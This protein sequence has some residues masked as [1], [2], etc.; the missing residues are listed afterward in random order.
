MAKPITKETKQPRQST[1][2]EV[3][4]ETE[5]GMSDD[6]LRRLYLK[7]LVDQVSAPDT[8]GK[9]AEAVRAEMELRKAEL[10]RIEKLIGINN[11]KGNKE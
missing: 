2:P 9:D 8:A 1:S 6:E 4:R 7:K 11:K 3:K 10:D 5:M